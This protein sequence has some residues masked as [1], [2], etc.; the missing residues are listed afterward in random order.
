MGWFDD[1]DQGFGMFGS[2]NDRAMLQQM[3]IG[4]KLSILGQTL[5]NGGNFMGAVAPVIQARRQ[6]QMD[7]MQ[8]QKLKLQMDEAQRKAAAQAQMAK[9]FQQGGMDP[10]AA[11]T[12]AA[13]SPAINNPSAYVAPQ[14]P[15]INNPSAFVAPQQ[16]DPAQAGVPAGAQPPVSPRRKVRADQYRQAAMMAA[17][18]GD[19]EGA[20]RYADIADSMDPS[21]KFTAPFATASGMAT[22]NQNDGTLRELGVQP[23]EATPAEI[24]QYQLAQQQGFQGSLLD[25]KRAQQATPAEIQAY[26][27]AQQQGFKGSILDYKKAVAAAG[28]SR[29]TLSPTIRVG[30]TLGD[31][32]AGKVAD[33]AIKDIGNAATASGTLNSIE[34]VRENLPEAITGPFAGFRTQV[35]RLASEVGLSDYGK[36]L[37][38]TQRTVQGLASMSLDGAKKLEGQGQITEFERALIEKA[39][40]APQSM[41]REEIMAATEAVE[42]VQRVMITRGMTQAEAVLANP[43][44]APLHDY[45]RGMTKG[46]SNRPIAPSTA[47][48]REAKGAVTDAPAAKPN[49]VKTLPTNVPP[50]T[51]AR[52]QRT[53]RIL[54]FDGKQWK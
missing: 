39:S 9:I 25:F 24:Q 4:M 11:A 33:V 34:Q 10:N 30:Q 43:N 2:G 28:A 19:S 18:M 3:P 38:A 48:G 20:K 32:L 51:R 29:T 41:S 35:A 23:H 50:G 12:V 40:S 6:A 8:Q 17:S 16:P 42:K 15:E 14:Q 36:K 45:V 37:A 27:L 47:P 31:Q 52:D 1:D 21:P 13:G 53:G 44:F 7:R 49:V 46:V 5:Q 54:T 26:Q 22:M